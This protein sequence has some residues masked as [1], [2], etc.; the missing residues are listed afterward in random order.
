MNSN[1]IK[2]LVVLCVLLLI[3]LFIEWEVSEPQASLNI[4]TSAT[5]EKPQ[6]QGQKLP[7]I[8]L[9][10]QSIDSY[11]HMV[12]SPLFIKG[13]KP[14]VDDIEE[15]ESEDVSRIEDL[16]L[17]GIYSIE[18]HLVALFIKKGMDGKHLKK[19]KGDDV[20]GWMLEEIKVDKVIL[21]RD[22]KKQ[23]LMLRAP[24]PKQP[25][26]TKPVRRKAKPVARKKIELKS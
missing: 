2:L 13:R 21:E 15:T 6:N 26:K 12:E 24:K 4:E 11:T 14:V 25:R 17:V 7:E 23:T 16:F 5:E 9:S 3:I 18:E 22:G 1:V 20:S 10:R 19:A 8:K